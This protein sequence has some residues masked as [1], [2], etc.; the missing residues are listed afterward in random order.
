MALFLK[1]FTVGHVRLEWWSSYFLSDLFVT[2][3]FVYSR[4]RSAVTDDRS[5]QEPMQL[6][7]RGNQMVWPSGGNK[8]REHRFNKSC[9]REQ[10]RRG[11]EQDFRKSV[12]ELLYIVETFQF[13]ISF[14]AE[15]NRHTEHEQRRNSSH[16]RNRC[17]SFSSAADGA[18]VPDNI[19]C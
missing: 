17:G 19:R 14:P 8:Y 10:G 9:Y 15:G 16:H 3:D 1:R 4:W 7:S 13:E 2:V 6:S 11:R 5:I 18:A 12:A